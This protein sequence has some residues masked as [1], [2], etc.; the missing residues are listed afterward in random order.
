MAWD[1]IY[2]ARTQQSLA[3]NL[4]N[5]A[6]DPNSVAYWVGG[7]SGLDV[8]LSQ[9]HFPVDP[10]LPSGHLPFTS[11]QT[12]TH[13]P[14]INRQ[15]PLPPPQPQLQLILIKRPLKRAL[16]CFCPCRSHR[17]RIIISLEYLPYFSGN[18]FHFWPLCTLGVG[19]FFHMLILD[20]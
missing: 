20:L 11:P 18:F 13:S 5:A 9:P 16:I 7:G 14:A 8:V 3:K 2:R 12:H 4:C 17:R 19:K 6:I 15:T 10:F 1:Y